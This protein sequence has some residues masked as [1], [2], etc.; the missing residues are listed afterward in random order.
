LKPLRSF[1]SPV[2]DL[3]KPMP[4]LEMQKMLDLPRGPLCG[5][6][7]GGFVREASDGAVDALVDA[8]EQSP[9][10]STIVVFEHFHGAVARVAT[11]ATAFSHRNSPHNVLMLSLWTEPSEKDRIVPW[12]RQSW[13]AMREFAGAGVYVNALADDAAARIREAYGPNYERLRAIK[14]RHDPD[15]FFRLNQN[16]EPAR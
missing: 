12:V 16:I 2:L 3:I 1:G 6:W 7:K 15:N 10:P 8:I 5:Y 14:K 4:Y 13:N 11:E 9:I